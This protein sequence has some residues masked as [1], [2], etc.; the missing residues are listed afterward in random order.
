MTRREWH[1]RSEFRRLLLAI[2]A[3][4]VAMFCAIGAGAWRMR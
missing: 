3:M 2:L 4:G 1:G